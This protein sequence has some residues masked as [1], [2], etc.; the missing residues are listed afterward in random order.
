[1]ASA[2]HERIKVS[3]PC[4]VVECHLGNPAF[5]RNTATTF[6]EVVP[7]VGCRRM[8]RIFDPPNRLVTVARWA[9]SS[10]R[11]FRAISGKY[12]MAACRR[13]SRRP[14]GDN[15]PPR[16]VP[17]RGAGDFRFWLTRAVAR[18]L[19][20]AYLTAALADGS[21]WSCAA[22]GM[23][24][25]AESS[26][27]KPWS[28][29]PD[30]LAESSPSATT[31]A[32]ST[33]TV[34]PDLASGDFV[35]GAPMVAPRDASHDNATPSASTASWRDAFVLPEGTRFPS[36]PQSS[37]L[38][39]RQIETPP[40]AARSTTRPR[41]SVPDGD[42]DPAWDATSILSSIHEPA[43]SDV[44]VNVNVSTHAT[45]RDRPAS[46][47]A[48]GE[49]APRIPRVMYGRNDR[50]PLFSGRTPHASK[51]L[52]AAA[53]DDASGTPQKIKPSTETEPGSEEAPEANGVSDTAS[54]PSASTGTRVKTGNAKK[55]HSL[56]KSAPG[57]FTL[58]VV[59]MLVCAVAAVAL[60]YLYKKYG[61]KN[62]GPGSCKA[63]E[64]LGRTYIDPKHYVSLVRVGRKV[65]VVG[66]AGGRMTALSEIDDDAEVVELL[67]QARPKTETGRSIFA[68]M[69]QKKYL[70]TRQ[71]A[72]A[73]G[74][75]GDFN[76]ASRPDAD[77]P[78][79]TPVPENG[80]RP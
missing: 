47:D 29:R 73:V 77:I 7:R 46:P 22:T 59:Y 34:A 24:A 54:A 65:L 52:R 57:R 62:A 32:P 15:A 38:V 26:A 68:T 66:V 67:E 53:A 41:A 31:P 12:F 72:A 5:L 11:A 17:R 25:A 49:G 78:A 58:V 14:G 48:V 1:M 35:P 61:P 9:G 21:A 51:P 79:S 30:V 37:P 8:G 18:L 74:F 28:G 70:R 80:S 16:L 75:S 69:F 45:L 71:D 27:R 44:A 3:F 76:A 42:V 50:K 40:A 60:A 39:G 63:M 19:V 10:V 20:T 2:R 55:N 23:A 36:G 43:P 6:R 4:P 56:G 64:V 33:S 13:R